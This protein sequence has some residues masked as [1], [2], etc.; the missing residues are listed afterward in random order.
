[1][2]TASL[3]RRDD[4]DFTLTMTTPEAQRLL[5]ILATFDGLDPFYIPLSDALDAEGI[6][7]LDA[8]EYLAAKRE[9]GRD[10]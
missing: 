1:M 5:G 4:P 3:A 9:A 7:Y 8:P 6:E 2:A 10:A